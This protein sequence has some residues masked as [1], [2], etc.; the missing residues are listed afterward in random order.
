MSKMTLVSERIDAPWGSDAEDS[1][2]ARLDAVALLFH[3]DRVVLHGLDVLERHAP[4]LLLGLR[5]HRAQAA[6]IDDE[7][8]GL[9]AEAERLK[10]PGRVRIRRVL[11]DAVGTDDQ[12]RSLAG[13]DRLD[14]TSGLLHLEN[15]VLVAIG[16]DGALPELKLLRRV[17]RG[18]HLHHVLLGELF[19]PGPAE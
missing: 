7:L 6:D 10:Q 17:G 18:L 4:G 16:H 3:R 1:C 19:E 12:W 13:I 5:M 14:R 9:R 8:L 2:I 15:V 11:E